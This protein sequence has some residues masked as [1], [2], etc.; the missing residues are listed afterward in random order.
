M[1]ALLVL[2]TYNEAENVLLLTRQ[3]LEIESRIDIVVVD[4]NS[5]DG[6]GDL[7]AQAGRDE[8]RLELI[9]REGKLGLGSAYLAGFAYGMERDYEWILTMDCDFSHR[10]EYLP[11]ILDM[12]VDYDLVIGSRY[13]RGGGVRNWPLH[14]RLLSEFA[15]RYARTLLRL[16]V[17]DCTSG[18]RCYRRKALESADPF[19]VSASG[20]SF[21]YE[22]VWR[23]H[24]GGFRIG[25]FPIVFEERRAGVSK[26]NRSEIL[27]AAL[28]VF[29]VGM[30]RG[31]ARAGG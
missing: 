25:E 5:P 2:P 9:R 23:I 21:L 3:V 13:V 31:K 24:D 14:R 20:Y 16:P 18:L 8:P 22:M 30:S 6:T 15:N 29:R 12:A 1:R 7:V 11:P 27:R 10:P 4:D 19:G 28:H 17:Q 26:I